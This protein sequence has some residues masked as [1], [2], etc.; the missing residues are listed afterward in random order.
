[1]DKG[2]GAPLLFSQRPPPPARPLPLRVLPR[3]LLY[4]PLPESII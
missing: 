1:M 2:V 4:H 3:A